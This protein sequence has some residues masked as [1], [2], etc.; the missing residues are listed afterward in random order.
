M[1]SGRNTLIQIANG[2]EMEWLDCDPV[3]AEG[4][5]GYDS[6]SCC[7]FVGNGVDPYSALCKICVAE[8]ETITTLVDNGDGTFTYTNETGTPVTIDVCDLVEDAGIL[9]SLT[10]TDNVNFTFNDGKGN[11]TTFSINEID[12]DINE[13]TVNNSVITFTAEDGTTTNV[14]ICALV[15]TNCNSPMVVN[16]DGSVTYTDNAGNITTIPAP[17]YSSVTNTIT[18][19]QIATHTSGDGTIIDVFESVTTFVDNGDCTYTYTSEDGTVTTTDEPTKTVYFWD[20]A[21][22]G[23]SEEIWTGAGNSATHDFPSEIFIGPREGECG[24]PSH[25]NGAPDISITVA[26]WNDNTA[27]DPSNGTDQARW[28]GWLYIEDDGTQIQ[29]VNTNSGERIRIWFDGQVVYE[30]IADTTG[31]VGSGTNGPFITTNKGWHYM[32]FEISDFSAFGGLNIQTS[33]DG[34]SFSNFNGLTSLNRPVLGCKQEPKSYTLLADE[35]D[36]PESIGSCYA[37]IPSGGNTSVL[38]D[39]SDGTYTHD[40]GTGNTVVIDTNQS[41]TLTTEDIIVGHASGFQDGTT[42]LQ[43]RNTTITRTAQGQYTVTFATPHP[44]GANYEVLFGVDEDASRD[45]SKVS[46]VKGTRTANGFDLIVTDDDNGAAADLLV[47][48]PWSFEVL[49]EIT[50]LTNVTI[51]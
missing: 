17:T 51:S 35:F 47:D 14:D 15:A 49:R 8:P 27:N 7:L 45:V 13:I 21:T 30:S 38:T 39:N 3:L 25:I 42:T 22:P 43:A 10:T 37:I 6:T 32:C 48:E 34:I 16:P 46:V 33:T 19:N 41:L 36:C 29:D 12:M 24:Q 50:V 4:Q 28:C 23:V 31:G 2:T 18:G 40:D 44:D 11:L 9:P 1:A 5:I 26:D 20:I